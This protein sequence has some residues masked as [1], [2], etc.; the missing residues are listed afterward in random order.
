LP[1]AADQPLPVMDGLIAASA[2]RHNL[3]VATRNV[4]DFIPC[5][6]QVINPWE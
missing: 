5:G 3:I 6:V 2:L 1:E 4:V